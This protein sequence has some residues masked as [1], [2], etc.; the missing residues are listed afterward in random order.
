MFKRK[1]KREQAILIEKKIIIGSGKRNEVS[2]LMRMR[3]GL[4][5]TQEN[6]E[7]KKKKE[8]CLY[9]MTRK[10]R[11]VF[12]VDAKAYNGVKIVSLGFINRIRS[13]L[14]SFE[15]QKLASKVDVEKLDW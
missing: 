2:S 8:Y 15:F 11:M 6:N 14:Q 3:F 12:G 1:V 4:Y 5:N 10:G 7:G 13:K 9:F